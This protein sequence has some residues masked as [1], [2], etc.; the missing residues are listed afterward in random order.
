[1]RWVSSFALVSVVLLAGCVPIPPGH[2]PDSRR[3]VPEEIPDWLVLGHTTMAEVFF[4]LGA[5]D[6]PVGPDGRTFG[7]V[8]ADM[9]GGVLIAAGSRGVDIGANS[10]RALIVRFDGDGVVTDRWFQS[11]LCIGRMSPPPLLECL[12]PVPATGSGHYIDWSIH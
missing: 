6:G 7:W 1:M 9:N 4:H 10:L 3:N 12:S 8:T 5:P 2:N 11:K